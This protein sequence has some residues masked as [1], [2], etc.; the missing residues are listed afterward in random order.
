MCL[1]RYNF[2]VLISLNPELNEKRIGCLCMFFLA[3]I[4]E[5]V[6]Q[7]QDVFINYPLAIQFLNVENTLKPFFLFISE[8]QDI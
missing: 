3:K 7:L 2:I 8:V 6:I 5:N 1:K 4:V